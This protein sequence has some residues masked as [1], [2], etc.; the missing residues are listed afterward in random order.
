MKHPFSSKTVFQYSCAT[1]FHAISIFA[2]SAMHPQKYSSG[3]AEAV[4]F[5]QF[6]LG[7]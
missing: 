3:P 2:G 4:R 1:N 7:H 6:W 5:V